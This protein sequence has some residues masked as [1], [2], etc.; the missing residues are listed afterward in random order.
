MEALVAGLRR[1]LPAVFDAADFSLR[2]VQLQDG[3][4]QR[5]E[6]AFAQLAADA[7]RS[8]V[9]FVRTPSAFEFAL[10]RD[11]EAVDRT[12]FESLANHEQRDIEH[13]IAQLQARLNELLAQLPDW[14]RETRAEIEALQRRLAQLAVQ[15][16]V[17][18]LRR[19]Y[20]G[21]EPV[22]V[23]LDRVQADLIEHAAQ[24]LPDGD[25]VPPSFFR[26][27][28]V[29]VMVDHGASQG[30]PV[31]YEDTPRLT[32]LV[33]SIGRRSEMGVLSADFTL[34]TSGALQRANGGYL[35]LD[36]HKLLAEPESWEALKRALQAR[37]VRIEC[38]QPTGSA[39]LTATVEPEPI[40]LDVKVVLLGERVLY[41]LLWDYDPD[42]EA[43]FKVAAD[44][45][46][47][48]E[49]SPEG[50]RLY[51]RLIGD[52]ARRHRLRALDRDAVARVVEHAARL[53]EDTER[54]TVHLQS[55]SDLLRESDYWARTRAAAHVQRIDVQKAIDAQI[56]R[57]DRVCERSYEEIHRGIVSIDTEGSRTGQVNGISVIELGGFAFGQPA[58]ISA[59]A[60]LGEGDIVDIERETELG[61]ALHSKGVLILSAYL[62]SRYCADKPLSLAAS[63][64][65]EQS[66]ASIEGDSASAAELC[67]LLSALA[68][69]P[70]RQDLGVTGA[71]NQYGD[72][73]AVGGVNEKIEGFYDICAARN[74]ND[75]QGVLIP[76]ANVAHLM[77]R[78]DVVQAVAEGRFAVYA[79]DHVD[80]VME[81]M[82]GVAAGQADDQGGFPD[83]SI[84]RRV[85]DRLAYLANIRH[86]FAKPASEGAEDGAD[87]DESGL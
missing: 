9:Q 8:G 63:L 43:L 42:F 76:R 25:P 69:A 86:E 74:L 58:R 16:S 78:E 19:A 34:T 10:Q 72:V 23:F 33:G 5:R 26:R 70:L 85:S 6:Q 84:N 53:S 7:E 39:A 2:V 11:G 77:L 45:E 49:W 65:F 41:Y 87:G 44:F 21:L 22:V 71:V 47:D 28:Q 59:T 40:P 29:K 24:F 32:N 56:R 57:M 54:I 79:V 83:A 46:D 17:D 14:Q 1:A 36:A 18:Q 52:L 61:G 73:Q 60:A 30:A 20:A 66:Y 15:K 4:K 50:L 38:P 48:M 12:R 62:A 82:T 81:L 37:E 31:V 55:I 51:A 35:L 75:K 3:F 13:A 68:L 27:Y 67:A 80:Q 64:V